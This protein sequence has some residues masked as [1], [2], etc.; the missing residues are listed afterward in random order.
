VN[1]STIDLEVSESVK[2]ERIDPIGSCE[3]SNNL[4]AAKEKEG[5]ELM[6]QKFKGQI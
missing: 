5:M 3:S 6:Q 1:I 2:S 4:S